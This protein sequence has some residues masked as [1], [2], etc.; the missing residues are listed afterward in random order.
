MPRPTDNPE[1]IKRLLPRHFEILELTLAGHDITAI[2]KATGFS[3]SGIQHVSKSALFQAELVRRR[4][5]TKGEMVILEADRERAL[6]KAR[7]I[8][9]K[10]SEFAA[11]TQAKLLHSG[12]ESVQF[13]AAK[14][15]LDRALGTGKKEGNA[16]LVL[17][18]SAEHVNLL[19]LAIKESRREIQS[20]DQAA[21]GST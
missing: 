5:E 9:D 12:N 6:G 14:D 11:T 3:T 17:N 10:A 2:A 4:Q 20:A 19:N 13:K 16:G 7:S 8:L 1:F 18:V 15:I 21:A